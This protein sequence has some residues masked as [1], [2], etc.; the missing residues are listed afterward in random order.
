MQ[1]SKQNFRVQ[2]VITVLSVVLFAAKIIAYYVTHSVAILSDALES[3]V[4]V[5]AGFIG[6]YALYIAAK[7]KDVEHPYGH[8]KAEFVSA[9]V[10]GT[11]IVASGFLII[12]QTVASLI[13]HKPIESLDTGIVLVVIT[14]IINFIA[15]S[16]C[17][18]VGK[19]N[20]SL[21]LQASG[22][23]LQIDTYSTIAIVAGLLVIVITRF[24]W[25]DKVIAI[26]ISII[27]LFN[28]YKIIRASLAGIMDE[29]DMQLLKKF[30]LELDK[31]K[32]DNWID[33]HNLRVIKYGTTLH[34]DCHLTIPWYLN[35]H[36][37]HE[38]I[39]ALEA[40]IIQTFGD[41]VELFV[42]TDGCLPFSCSICGVANC[43]E[44]QH[45]F[46]RRLEWTLANILSNE[47]H[48]AG[49]MNNE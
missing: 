33:L 8:G 22:K 21:A 39:D 27:I 24:Y 41:A 12:Y 7:P 2:L 18:S 17:I 13:E 47:K 45:P 49:S 32:K 14:A 46:K 11:L 20:R 37:A 5:T 29:A 44:R 1:V 16:I 30:V 31:H 48:N 35:I 26:I 42:H 6:L 23:H 43:K 36:Q 19:R 3:V 10:E 38:E 9:A 15:G 40:L 4:N 28:G 34:I 25:L